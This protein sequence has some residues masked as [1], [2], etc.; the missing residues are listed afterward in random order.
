MWLSWSQALQFLLW[1]NWTNT[2]Q[3]L[4]PS[5]PCLQKC[6]NIEIDD[7]LWC[8]PTYRLAKMGLIRIIHL[9]FLSRLLCPMCKM[10][11]H[12]A[13][14]ITFILFCMLLHRA[15]QCVIRFPASIKIYISFKL[16]ATL[17]AI[18]SLKK[19]ISRTPY[20]NIFKCDSH[21]KNL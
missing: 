6:E 1:K 8:W 3:L 12:W 21:L 11:D 5:P 17:L 9:L 18:A 16:K 2:M 4:T 7:H 15:I 20:L 14:G 13:S 19:F 10:H